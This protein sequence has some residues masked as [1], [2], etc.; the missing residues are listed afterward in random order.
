MFEPLILSLES[1]C[2]DTAAAVM[3]GRKLLSHTVA[4]QLVHERY[5]GVVPELASRAHEQHILPTVDRV[6]EKANISVEEINAIG[7]TQGP[8]LLGSL[9][10]GI[11][12]ANGLG[13]ARKLPVI[14]IHHTRA[15][16]LA[17]LI[18]SPYPSFPFL[19][20]VVSGGHTQLAEVH[21]PLQMTLLGST[22]DDAAGEA[23][24]KI[25]KMLGLPYPG[26]MHIDKLASQ[27]D[28]M[29]FAFP[30]TK[31]KGFDFSFSGL[32]TAFLYF[33]KKQTDPHFVER[34]LHDLCASIQYTIVAIL[35]QKLQKAMHES[36]LKRI[37]IGGGVANNSLLRQEL[38]A[39]AQ[40]Y[41]WEVFIPKPIYCSDNAA[42]IAIATYYHLE[43]GLE[44]PT[45]IPPMPRMPFSS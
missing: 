18:E 35:L 39:A 33:L 17:N 13:I 9:L 11:A 21:S 23:F 10:V 38:Y 28:P 3:Q 42:M 41:G 34:N 16:L 27:G 8:G 32:K 26:G 24:D 20:L 7:V 44:E 45:F 2:D 14:G 31:T 19:G 25:A 1:S 36:S 40:K 6:L 43:A 22:L 30:R 29:R 4:S 37:A 15:H 5:G 12:F